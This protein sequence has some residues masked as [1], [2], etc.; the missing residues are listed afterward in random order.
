MRPRT[1]ASNASAG[2]SSIVELVAVVDMEPPVM[3]YAPAHANS[4][5][6]PIE[7]TPD[8]RS[9]EVATPTSPSLSMLPPAHP[10]VQSFRSGKPASLVRAVRFSPQRRTRR[11]PGDGSGGRSRSF[12]RDE[13]RVSSGHRR[14]YIPMVGSAPNMS[15]SGVNSAPIRLPTTSTPLCVRRS[16]AEAPFPADAL[17]ISPS[18]TAIHDLESTRQRRSSSFPV[19]GTGPRG[20]ALRRAGCFR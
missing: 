3:K 6:R 10:A 4:A 1:R 7:I 5:R 11:Q 19:S 15:D 2:C 17:P 20:P 14:V 9:V 18:R 16:R 13:P 8:H 12:P